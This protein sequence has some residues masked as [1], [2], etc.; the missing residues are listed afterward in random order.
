MKVKN[1][2]RPLSRF[3]PAFWFITFLL[4]GPTWAQEGGGSLESVEIEIVK[5]KQITLPRANR[6]FEKIPPRPSE[7]IVPEITYSFR[8]FNFQTP[9]VNPVL[10]PLK[11]KQDESR[12]ASTGYVSAG[13]GNYAAPYLDGFLVNTRSKS[14]TYGARAYVNNFGRGPVDEKNSASGATGFSVFG[15]T[16]SKEVSLNGLIGFDRRSLNFYG[17]QPGLEVDNDTIR[18]SIVNFRIN[19][20][21]ANTRNGNFYYTLTA[22][23][24]YLNDKFNASESELI[25]GLDG[26]YK[27]SE[28]KFVDVTSRYSLITRKDALVDA[29]PRSLFQAGATYRFQYNE[30]IELKAGAVVAYENDS[31]DTKAF[32]LYPDIK[33]TYTLSSKAQVY[34]ALTGGMEKV[35]LHTLL[36]ENGWLAPNIAIF[37]TNKV[38][39]VQAGIKVKPGNRL[40]G[41]AG[42]SF[43]N[44]KHPFFYVNDS[45]NRA[46]FQ[47]VYDRAT[48]RTNLFGELK[49]VQAPVLTASLRADL[50]SY[51]TDTQAEAFHRPRYRITSDVRYVLYKK[52]VF[53]LQW[54]TQG[55]S[56]VYNVD[57]D[58]IEELKA[59]VDLS[60]N[61]EYLFSESLSAFVNLMNITSTQN[62]VFLNYP[63]RGLQVRVGANW[64][65]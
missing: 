24:N 38:Y 2:I 64:R 61:T 10:R 27:I 63:V 44:L 53:G 13:Y 30:N 62:A 40:M 32:H 20:S 49:Y 11:L 48:K 28:N 47:T 43:A 41:G 46:K 35:S 3:V 42:L 23:F 18:Q 36:A 59:A 15:N 45:T 31:I 5:D 34:G 65:F 7:P 37:H 55:K 60:F 33:A 12:P 57:T 39:D 29:K 22:D 6:I 21:L 54:A 17:Y 51:S 16:I 4:Y 1:S 26:A 8:A 56:K 50:F 25:F 52:I 9:P 14:K 58:T 19:T